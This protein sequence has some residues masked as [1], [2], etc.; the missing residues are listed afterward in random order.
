MLLQY[1]FMSL[2]VNFIKV[3]GKYQNLQGIAVDFFV[4]Q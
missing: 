4:Y 2:M 3:A 1:F